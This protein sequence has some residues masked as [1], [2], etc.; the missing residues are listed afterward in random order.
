MRE[1]DMSEIIW[2]PYGDYLN[3][4]NIARF[5]KKHEIIGYDELIE[6]SVEDTS[7]FWDAALDDL[8]IEWYEPYKAVQEG[9]FPFAK[10]FV[11]G[12]TNVVLNCIDR[13][14]RDGHGERLAIIYEDEEGNVTEWTYAQLDALVSRCANALKEAG[15]QKG[16]KVGIYMP[17]V[18]EIVAAFFAVMKIGAV[19]IPVFSG[20]G[21]RALADRMDDAKAKLLFTAD[22]SY[23]R[24]KIFP[25]KEEADRAA[26]MAESIETIVVFQR[27]GA[28]VPMTAGRDVTWDD[29]IGGESEHCPTE[30][31][32]A[33]DHALIIYTSGTTG[34]PKGTIHTH[35]GCLA[36]MGKELGYAFD[37]KVGDVFF[38]FTDIGWMM[39]P[40]EMIG[41]QIF[42][43][44]YVL[45]DGAPNH[46]NPDRVWDLVERHKITHLGISPTA[47]RL[48]KTYDE[49]WV[50]KHPMSTLKYLGSTGEAWDLEAYMW[51][52]EKVG[53]KR[54]PI[55]NISGGTE[56]IGCHLSPLP[57]TELKPCTLRG[58][59]LG[60]DV[61]VFD[62]EG[63][64]LPVG[65]GHL[66]CKQPAPSMTK[67]FLGDDQRYL[68]TYF[69]VFDDIWFHGDWAER[70]KDGFW[71]LR[72][73]SDDTIKIAGKR[74]GPSEIESAALQHRDAMEAA[75]V[76]IPDDIKGEDA[77][78][79][80]VIKAGVEHT[81]EL[82]K[83]I[84]D[85]VVKALG[86]TLR[87]KKVYFVDDL[88]KTRSAKILR[89]VV[90]EVHL[91]K[92][93]GELASCANP[94]AIDAVKNA[95]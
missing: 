35:A 49:E 43:S 5:M 71:F 64:S 23:R 57:I 91:G 68:D 50:T 29:F 36:Q 44:T 70:D 11:G 48:L 86:K 46:P 19:V 14:N 61:D 55:I 67:G 42:G 87:P 12:K 45:F 78:V 92:R 53:R 73:R 51:F 40:W 80:V 60:M 41:V 76:G 28:E 56:I 6:R 13:H 77:A 10:W 81:E 32:E 79:F 72:G 69:S 59:G 4:S 63:N 84:S 52:F 82:R 66:V 2:R 90:K 83:A 62:E 15:I 20:F 93:I 25:I 47:I 95:H 65:I 37:V 1:T 7:W 26:V 9:G 54:C 24:G 39:G 8:G 89:R 88:P 21:A 18:P 27:T 58:P 22:G 30:V 3:K 31:M 85:Q 16:D 75:A 74:T 94:A 38:W 33:E 34:K 17:M